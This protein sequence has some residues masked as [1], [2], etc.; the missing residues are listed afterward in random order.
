MQ[1]PRSLALIG[2]AALVG[3][4]AGCAGTPIAR[5]R[6]ARD[7][8][9]R[10]GNELRPRGVK[11][12]LPALGAESP[13]GEFVRY[14][15]LNHPAVEAAYHDWRASVEAI[16]PARSLP[17]PQLT[18]EA[19]ISDMLMTLMPGVMFDLMAP[20]KRAAMGNEA[21]AKS[22]V[23]Y[24]AYVTAVL[25]A[26]VAVRKT[27]VELAYAN[28]TQRL[29]IATI[30]NL[31][32]AVAVASAEYST[33][34]GMA[35][36]DQLVRLRNT[37][38]EHHSHHETAGLRLAAGWA[39]FKSALGH[40]PTDPD[41]PW[42]NPVLVATTVPSEEELW[43]AAQL[44]NPELGSM[45]AMV[46]MAV[47]EIE[48]AQKA[49]TPDFMVGAMA[50]LKASPLMVRPTATVRLP[51]WREKISGNIAA[52]QAR[53]DAAVARVGAEQLNL[54]GEIA[55][56]LFMVRESDRMI[57]YIEKTAVPNLEQAVASA[58]AGYQS[59]I[60]TPAM[61]PE[62]RHMALL[63]RLE[64]AKALFDRELAA[65]DLLVVMTGNAP[66]GAPLLAE[67]RTE[68]R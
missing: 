31:A 9:T 24:R 1:V 59:G 37:A 54:V 18:F 65:A 6:A 47:A 62:A 35:S 21:A 58:E 10:V 64:R 44:N 2:A 55:Q 3:V 36:L 16:A 61:I 45:R 14:A 60:G 33:G 25:R 51:I 15:V 7:Q 27:W 57:E 30:Q 12:T 4:L 5:E 13:V 41:P 38:A 66:A 48:I 50:D 26:A 8:V 34:R 56:M 29:Y 11:P 20:G 39:R 32:Q 28:E 17:D 53:R 19:D 67:T 23:A 43:R 68:H 40:L 46:E 52:A 22:G 42:P 49:R 63:M